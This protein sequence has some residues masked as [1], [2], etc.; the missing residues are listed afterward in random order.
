MSVGPVATAFVKVVPDATGFRAELEKAV[1]LAVAQ[2]EKSGAATVRATVK[3]S[4]TAAAG[5]GSG[6][7]SSAAAGAAA[8]KAT[9]S[10]RSLANESNAA[11]GALIGLSR[12]TP[13]TVFGLGL[14]GSA[15]IVAGTAVKRMVSSTA[16]FE[17]QL[18]ILQATTQATAGE[19]QQIHDEALALGADLKLPATSASDAAV[20]MTE[21]AKAGLSVQDTLAAARGVLQLAAAAEISAGSAAI[22]VSTA[23]NAFSLSGK[24]A[25][26]I[27]DLL[28]G[29]SIA[30]QGS[31][32][33]FGLGLNQVSA[34]AVQVGV[35]VETTAGALTELARAGLRG[36]DGGTSLRTT[37]LRLAPTTK[38]ASQYMEALGIRIDKTKS[39]GDQLP[40]LIDQ[41][42]AALEALT[43]VQQQQALAQIFGQDAIRAASI[44]IRGGSEALRDATA[45]ADQ[46]GAAARLAAANAEG[47][48]GA[49]AGLKSNL[50][51]LGITLGEVAQG[52]L[53]EFVEG[54]AI[55]AG[56]A[57]TAANAVIDFVNAAGQIP[58]LPGKDDF[59]YKFASKV[60]KAGVSPILLLG[61]LLGKDDKTIP[62][63]TGIHDP[64]S[65]GAIEADAKNRLEFDKKEQ[66]RIRKA[67]QALIDSGKKAIPADTTA[68]IALESAKLKAQINESLQGELKAD[69]AIE[70]YFE[71]RLGVAKK[72]TQRYLIILAAY[73]SAHSATASVQAQI[74][75]EQQAALDDAE[76]ERKQRQADAEQA[77]R[78]AAQAAQDLFNLQ[79]SS[80]GLEIQR[81]TTLF[82][83][84]K[85]LA[86]KAY[87]D[88]IDFIQ[89]KIR[90][91]L[92]V[93][94][95]TVEMKQKILDYKKEVL[96]LQGAIK[97]LNSKD[98]DGQ[99]GFSLND[100]YKASVDSFNEFASNVSSSPTTPGTA[101]SATFAS[102]VKRIPPGN[103][104]LKKLETAAW[105]QVDEGKI[106]NDL[107]KAILDA[108]TR[109]EGPVVSPKR[110]GRYGFHLGPVSDAQVAA[111]NMT[112]Q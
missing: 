27:A 53:T 19:M 40:Q 5:T 51:T 23:L 1:K 11:R 42:R 112:G 60:L 76:R 52:P 17:H 73:Q 21:L 30:A 90:E 57:T 66:A 83:N 64:S 14:Y 100:L 70:D 96:S 28:A 105:A 93:K 65:V 12:I 111:A 101:A 63:T 46:N 80:Y 50:D 81:V 44:L 43:P 13:V 35:D 58:G 25:V 22:Y 48:S 74:D 69:K 59:A 98:E 95:K 91:L 4:A 41:Y 94:N 110:K 33:D 45:A 82:P 49:Y 77:A 39:I 84:N 36:S 104:A 78:D 88:E 87:Q 102:I 15:A 79:K 54:L 103:P 47:L 3:A 20:A 55:A 97:D 37:L 56:A 24:E 16:E 34:V 75:A 109:A 31:I 6:A 72:G 29:A 9:T 10:V 62:D 85:K 38:Q 108:V 61:D 107:L 7:A 67:V 68:P 71:K 18:N 2:V 99:G 106:S 89:G 26:H 92:K 8:A 32:E 86:R